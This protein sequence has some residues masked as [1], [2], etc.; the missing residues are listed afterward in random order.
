M[1]AL[2]LLCADDSLKSIFF[3]FIPSRFRRL[4]SSADLRCTLHVPCNL[5]YQTLSYPTIHTVSKGGRKD[6]QGGTVHE[7]CVV[8]YFTI[9]VLRCIIWQLSVPQ[10]A[11]HCSNHSNRSNTN[12][13]LSPM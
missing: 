7:K 6:N 5:A 4:A 2:R 12:S 13:C 3:F 1:H 10:M 9:V 8:L 11:P